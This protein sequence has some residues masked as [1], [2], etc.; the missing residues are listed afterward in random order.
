MGL[1]GGKADH[2]VEAANA[3]SEHSRNPPS[4]LRNAYA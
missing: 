4:F 1:R 2:G 3:R